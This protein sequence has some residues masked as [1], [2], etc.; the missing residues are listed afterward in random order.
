MLG[1]VALAAM[2]LV[3]CEKKQ[4]VK[5]PPPPAEVNVISVA[6][7]T[8]PVEN[9]FVAQVESAHQVEIVTRVNGFLEKI[10]YQEGDVVKLGQLMFQ[11]DQKPF[12][13]QVEAAKGSLANNEAQL[14]TAKANLKRVEPLAK[15]DAASKS[16]LDNAIGSVQSAS[17]GKSSASV[18]YLQHRAIQDY[19][20]SV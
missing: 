2:A 12:I 11:L 6:P 1:G 8:I 20:P 3:G 7:Q 9:S 4:E 15:L 16:D 13:A 14:W 5:A 17:P 18:C 10:L 19:K